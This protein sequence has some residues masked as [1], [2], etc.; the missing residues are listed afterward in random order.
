MN[1]GVIWHLGKAFLSSWYYFFS[2]SKEI[3]SVLSTF[4][5]KSWR[6]SSPSEDSRTLWGL[7]ITKELAEWA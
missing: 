2:H 1:E 6:I 7:E 3:L 4:L 5:S